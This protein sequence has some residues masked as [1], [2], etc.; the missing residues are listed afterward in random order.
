LDSSKREI[1]S[2]IVCQL[3]ETT[4]GHEH[5]SVSWR[6]VERWGV[7]VSLVPAGLDAEAAFDE[8][9]RLLT[10]RLDP[11]LS[12]QSAP[13]AGDAAGSSGE[14]QLAADAVACRDDRVGDPMAMAGD[15]AAAF[16]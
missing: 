13:I 16:A 12:G 5:W 9:I 6:T 11:P 8:I 15:H 10:L 14:A 3:N 1:R 4:L 2:I 7:S